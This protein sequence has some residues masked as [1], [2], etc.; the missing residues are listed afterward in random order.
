M[1]LAFTFLASAS[2]GGL[3]GH[4]LRVRM[5][6]L[7]FF[8]FPHPRFLWGSRITMATTACSST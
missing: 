4:Q 3:K 7:F 1:V 6:D 2:L 5:S 8:L